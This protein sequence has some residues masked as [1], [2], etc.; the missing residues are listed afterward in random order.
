MKFDILVFLENL[1]KNFKFRYN[2]TRKL[3]TL[4]DDQYMIMI[5]SHLDLLRMR[6]FFRQNL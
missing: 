6:I 1:P 2:V 4:H 3:G 5:I